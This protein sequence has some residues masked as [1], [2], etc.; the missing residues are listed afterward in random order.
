VCSVSLTAVGRAG[1]ELG[2]ATARG[3][4]DLSAGVAGDRGLGVGEDGADVEAL[5]AFHIEEE[6]VRGLDELLELVHSVLL[7]GVRVQKV[8][9]HCVCIS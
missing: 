6:R 1:G 2:T 7:D 8:H 4:E 5:G 3:A 9:F